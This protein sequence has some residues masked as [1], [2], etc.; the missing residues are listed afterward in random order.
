MTMAGT[1]QAFAN[2]LSTVNG[3]RGYT[4]KPG[5]PRP[6]D[7]W[8]QWTGDTVDD[9]S[10][11]MMSGWSVLVVLPQDERAA[12]EWIDEHAQEL[13]DALQQGQVAYVD[14]FAPAN[15]NPNGTLYGL[16]ITTRSE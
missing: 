10:G 5:A 4:Y 14:G 1:R 13:G 7:A 15:L 11:Q 9:A 6:G 3:V 16:L 12:D 8:A 2:A